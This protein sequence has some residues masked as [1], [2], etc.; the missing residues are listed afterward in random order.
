MARTVR[1]GRW[2]AHHPCAHLPGCCWGS[3]LEN[4]ATARIPRPLRRAKE[5]GVPYARVLRREIC[6]RSAS[7]AC[8]RARPRSCRDKGGTSTPRAE[9]QLE[10]GGGAIHG[11]AARL[12]F[13]APIVRNAGP[14]A[15][16]KEGPLTPPSLRVSSSSSFSFSIGKGGRRRF[17]HVRRSRRR[18]RA[19]RGLGR[20]RP[21]C[22]RHSRRLFPFLLSLSAIRRR[23]R[24]AVPRGPLPLSL[25]LLLLRHDP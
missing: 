3:R 1:V 22:S 6:F 10:S 12:R 21:G 13:T 23:R 4:P 7:P 8:C 18:E 19:G 14:S 17:R 15:M 20:E 24:A 2:R 11:L 25:G 9:D 5:F 16:R